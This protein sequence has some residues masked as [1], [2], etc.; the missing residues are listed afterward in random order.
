MAVTDEKDRFLRTSIDS[1]FGLS[2]EEII[3]AWV[4]TSER[5]R[6]WLGNDRT[7]IEKCI[8]II[9]AEGVSATLFIAYDYNEQGD[10]WGWLNHTTYSGDP[11]SDARN[12][13]KWMLE[14]SNSTY[15]LAWYDA[16]FP[17]YTTPSNLQQEGQEYYDSLAMSTVGRV[18]LTG[19]AA[20]TWA[21]FDENGL[22]ASYN[23]VKDYGDPIANAIKV[24]KYWGGTIGEESD[25]D[26]VDPIEP[27]EPDNETDENSS[28][29]VTITETK[30]VPF[31]LTGGAYYLRN[32]GLHH[33]KNDGLIMTRTNDFL[34]P[35]INT[36]T[37]TTTVTVDTN[38][39]DKNTDGG[40]TTGGSSGGN[41]NAGGDGGGE[42]I[43]DE[44]DTA[45][46]ATKAYLG[47][48]IGDGQCYA[49]SAYYSKQ[50]GGYNISS[51]L[52]ALEGVI[53]DTM[54]ASNIGS[55]YSWGELG[56]IVVDYPRFDQLKR[57]DIINYAN[58][59]NMSPMGWFASDAY[60]HTGVIETVNTDGT[61]FT[62][63]QWAPSDN[64]NRPNGLVV[65]STYN[66]YEGMA[67]SIV[68]PQ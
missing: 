58:G 59:A 5:V 7:N 48:Y 2:K 27:E 52:G 37:S 15:P 51:S 34:Y 50:L 57:G 33:L 49:L 24:I 9:Q 44:I 20:A 17:Y 23:H 63:E 55:G 18:Y 46:E 62:L 53:G 56:W 32:N 40:G 68:R 54:Q 35:K 29:E 36:E 16:A 47:S 8:D 31:E 38:T 11:Y 45:L 12:V 6:E 3:D 65:E 60:G 14:C 41:S 13:A 4:D 43:S 21:C 67:K 39:D 28:H 61:I 22:S 64:G 19:T 42:D 30:D 26:P 25:P 1:E 66:F 10:Y